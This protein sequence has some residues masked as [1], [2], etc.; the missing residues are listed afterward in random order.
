MKLETTTLYVASS[1]GEGGYAVTLN[2]DFPREGLLVECDC[3]AG[4]NNTMCKHRIQIIKGDASIYDPEMYEG[5]GF[6]NDEWAMSREIVKRY[7]L[8]AMVSEYERTLAELEKTK[9][10]ITSQIRAEKK[11][12]QRIFSEGVKIAPPPSSSS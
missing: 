2:L 3:P 12:L 8:N 1:S 10:R 7:G 4:M 6:Y 9:K 5:D 11:A